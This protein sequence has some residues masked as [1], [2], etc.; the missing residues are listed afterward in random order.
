MI[1][2]TLSPAELLAATILTDNIRFDVETNPE[3]LGAAVEARLIAVS[4]GRV[5][6]T[7]AGTFMALAVIVR[8]PVNDATRM[9]VLSCP[10]CR[11]PGGFCPGG[12]CQ[13]WPEL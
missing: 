11:R 7:D 4:D 2:V 8:R 6:L 12:S 10:L 5:E 1:A 9:A 3:A 13:V